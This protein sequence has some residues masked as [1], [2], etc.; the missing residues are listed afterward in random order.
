MFQNRPQPWKLRVAHLV[1]KVWS[2]TSKPLAY[3]YDVVL[4]RDLHS[5]VTVVS[6]AALAGSAGG[7]RVSVRQICHVRCG[8]KRYETTTVF[9]DMYK[10]Y[11][12]ARGGAV[13]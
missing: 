1:Q 9:T 4:T 6:M 10:H 2:L 8:D 7:G 13:C 11:P 5:L 3:F 12:G